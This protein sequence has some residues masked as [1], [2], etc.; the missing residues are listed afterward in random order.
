M[1]FPHD[2]FNDVLK[3][4]DP[5]GSAEL[6][7]DHHEV[8]AGA[9]EFLQQFGNDLG[10]RDKNRRMRQLEKS[11]SI[12]LLLREEVLRINHAADL[13]NVPAIDRDTAVSGLNEKFLCLF[14]TGSTGEC[15]QIHPGR[16]DCFDRHITDFQDTA[17]HFLFP[18]LQVTFR[19]LVVTVHVRKD[20]IFHAD[21]F[22]G[23]VCLVPVIRGA[24]GLFQEP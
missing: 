13:I 11:L 17:D 8:I 5:G 10:L 24:V 21:F 22:I 18:F 1:D 3:G 4:G 16:H 23:V 9:F 15:N 19:V 2:L 7:N 12:G 20:F 14:H 6:V